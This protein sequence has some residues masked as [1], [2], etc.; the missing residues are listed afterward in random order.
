MKLGWHRV[1]VVLLAAGVF[2]LLSFDA[3]AQCAMCRAS[4]SAAGN[5]K[6]MQGLNTGVLVLLLPPV[7]I[8]CSIFY[9]LRKNNKETS[10]E[11]SDE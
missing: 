3:S 6:F 2:L 11:Q 9:I 7:S 5:D 10:H 1:V 4:L 8:F